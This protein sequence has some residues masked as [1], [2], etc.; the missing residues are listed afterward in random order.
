LLVEQLALALLI[1]S[2]LHLPVRLLRH[3]W[4]ILI[5]ILIELLRLRLLLIVP[6]ILLGR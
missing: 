3:G 6:E 4:L 2:L 1:I 5:L